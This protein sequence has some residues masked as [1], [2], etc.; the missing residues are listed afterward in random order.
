[1][2]EITNGQPWQ[3]LSHSVYLRGKKRR[4]FSK[5]IPLTT[6]GTF[7]AFSDRELIFFSFLQSGPRR[8]AVKTVSTCTLFFLG[9]RNQ[10]ISL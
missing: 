4:G 6:E 5:N 1:V 8:K 2:V 10:S 3:N 9:G 7:L